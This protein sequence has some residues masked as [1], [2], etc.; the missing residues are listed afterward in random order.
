MSNIA[1]WISKYFWKERKTLKTKEANG[2]DEIFV[3]FIIKFQLSALQL[4]LKTME[5]DPEY[6]Y[7][8]EDAAWL[9]IDVDDAYYKEFRDIHLK[10]TTQYFTMLKDCPK[11]D[12]ANKAIK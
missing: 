1:N 9:H 6:R 7:L 10:E 4:G 8:F 3:Y 5:R 2:N 11:S 12:A